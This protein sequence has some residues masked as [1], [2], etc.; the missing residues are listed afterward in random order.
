[1]CFFGKYVAKLEFS[2]GTHWI[3]R[4]AFHDRAIKKVFSKILCAFSLSQTVR[5]NALILARWVCQ[6][7]NM[8]T[9]PSCVYHYNV[10]HIQLGDWAELHK[11]GVNI[12]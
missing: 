6:T 10:Y 3:N 1:M 9:T 12:Y 2:S 5:H 8:L 4:K 7:Y 11:I